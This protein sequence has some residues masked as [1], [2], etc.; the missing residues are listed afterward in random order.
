MGCC[1]HKY[2]FIHDL[3]SSSVTGQMVFETCQNSSDQLSKLITVPTSIAVL[4]TL[5]LF[6][7]A[8]IVI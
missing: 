1:I 6:L 4:S 3:R 5:I 2:L 8:E 7:H